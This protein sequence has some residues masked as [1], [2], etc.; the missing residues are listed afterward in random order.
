[1]GKVRPLALRSFCF[2]LD[3][4]REEETEG[5]ERGE[6]RKGGR[7]KMRKRCD[8]D[9]I[10]RWLQASNC[11][12]RAH[13]RKR[14]CRLAEWDA[15]WSVDTLAWFYLT[16]MSPSHRQKNQ[17]NSETRGNLV[18]AG[19]EECGVERRELS[20]AVSCRRVSNRGLKGMLA[21]G[22]PTVSSCVALR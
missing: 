20:L 21:F 13:P 9:I 17:K 15:T 14:R 2:S 8:G 5:G 6:R 4:V 12:N 7:E 16:A 18:V 3:M 22:W 19:R 10:S 11:I 1:M